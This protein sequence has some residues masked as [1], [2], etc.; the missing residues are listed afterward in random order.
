MQRTRLALGLLLAGGLA[1]GTA[2]W[3]YHQLAT[4]SLQQEPVAQAAAAGFVG[5]KSCRGCHEDFYKLW[6]VSNHGLA[7]QPYSA[8]LARAKLKPPTADVA[9]GKR[10]YRAEIAPGTGWVRELGPKGE[11]RYPIA[12]VMGGKN[13]YYFLTLLEHGRLQ[14]LPVAYDVRKGTWYDTAASGVRHFPDRRDEALDWKDRM[15]TFNTTC[16]N[17]HVSQLATN[18]DFKTDAYRTTWAEPGISCESCHGPAGRHVAVMEQKNPPTG[19][20]SKSIRIVR[21]KEFTPQQMNDLCAACHAKII[22]L[23]NAFLPGD[24][25]FDHY[26]LL[27]LEHADFYPDG[28]D[29]GENYTQ[30]SWLMNPCAKSGKLDCNHCHTPSGRMRFTAER[31][32]EACLPCH[33]ERVANA[34]A[35]THH[36][37]DSTGNKCVACHMPMTRFAQ[38]GRSDHSVRPPTPATTLAFKSP[39]ACNLCH[40]DHDAA[41]SDGYVR[42]WYPKDYQAEV[43]H[44]AGLVDA[45]RKGQWAKLPEILAYLENKKSDVVFKNSLVRA[46]RP[47]EDMRKWPVLLALLKDPSPLVRSSAAA[48]LGDRLTPETVAGLVAAAGDDYR[49]VRI[50]AAMALAAVPVELLAEGARKTLDR[51][52]AEFKTAMQARPDDWASYANLGNFHMERREYATA[53]RFFETATKLEPRMIGPIVNASIAYSNLGRDDEAEKCLRRALALA[54]ANAAANLNLGM[55]LGGSGRLD[56]AERALRVAIKSDPQLAVAAYNL[57]VVLHKKNLDEAIQWYKKACALQPNEPK[58][59][60]ALALFQRQKG[61]TAEAVRLLLAAIDRQP[62]HLDSVLLLGEIYESLSQWQAAETVYRRALNRAELSPEDRSR[63]E[64]Q[65]QTLGQRQP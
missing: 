24:R 27:T 31:I 4:D 17:C 60:C 41:W 42:K 62:A 6:V 46:L 63:L 2:W 18:Y 15:F 23:S 26:D 28:R 59:T 16:F 53:V 32:N 57:G 52:V 25:F 38:M 9:I 40:T 58:Y 22:P 36:K 49:L 30:T 65:L 37:P 55:L 19:L 56:E 10:R 44:V 35:H 51:A 64:S 43:L 48:A 7:M 34:T 39:N 45:A 3:Y 54:P 21:T 14:V 12:H 13:T 29:L 1:A 8:E 5:S 47:C 20:D 11:I 50:R 33:A 61:D